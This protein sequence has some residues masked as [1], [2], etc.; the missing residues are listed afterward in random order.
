MKIDER[1]VMSKIDK[2]FSI[3][4]AKKSKLTSDDWKALGNFMCSLKS[5]ED[6][7][8]GKI[9]SK[10]RKVT[11]AKAGIMVVGSFYPEPSV[12]IAKS[13]YKEFNLLI[14]ARDLASKTVVGVCAVHKTPEFADCDGLYVEVG[15]RLLGIG[16]A[17]LQKAFEEVKKSGI[18][19]LALRVSVMNNAARALYKKLGFSPTAYQMERWV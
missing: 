16:S 15:Y 13:M 5:H 1:D 18:A 8:L 14:I 9:E 10:Q 12:A 7:W 6:K 3:E 4:I 11:G 19:S 17:L 2:R